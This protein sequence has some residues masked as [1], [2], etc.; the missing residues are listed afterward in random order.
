VANKAHHAGSFPKRSALVRRMAYA[1]PSTRCWR[2]GRTLPEHG[3]RARWTA[4][5]VIDGQIDGELRPEASTCNYS[6]GAR[7]RH[8]RK[9]RGPNAW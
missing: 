3:P 1:D 8:E 5:H 7:L 4:G 9:R 2:C 6:A